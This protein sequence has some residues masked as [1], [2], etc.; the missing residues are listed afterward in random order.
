MNAKFAYVLGQVLA[1]REFDVKFANETDDGSGAVMHA[2]T[3]QSNEDNNRLDNESMTNVDEA[4]AEVPA[5]QL[6]EILNALDAEITGDTQ[7]MPE[8]NKL[9]KQTVFG[10][11]ANPVA[12]DSGSRSVGGLATEGNTNV[13]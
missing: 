5:E 10:P 9:D 8:P 13:F 3:D 11:Q 1:C 6:A 7:A 12:G 4:R 2:P